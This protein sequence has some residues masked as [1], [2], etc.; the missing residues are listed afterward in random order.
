MFCVAFFLALIAGYTHDHC[1]MPAWFSI[2]FSICPPGSLDF[3]PTGCCWNVPETL[4]SKHHM[5]L[6]FP[7]TSFCLCLSLVSNLHVDL[8]P[9]A[10]ISWPITL[11]FQVKKHPKSAQKRRRGLCFTSLIPSAP[12]DSENY[13]EIPERNGHFNGNI[14]ELNFWDFLVIRVWLQRVH[15]IGITI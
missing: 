3:T 12:E 1:S 5:Y 10:T 11:Q 15:E 6:C 14:L 2:D 13:W 4:V 9:T 8:F 7:K